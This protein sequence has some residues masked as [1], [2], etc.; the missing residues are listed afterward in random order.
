MGI[1]G[2]VLIDK[3]GAKRMLLLGSPILSAGLFAMAYYVTD[4]I[5][6]SIALIL[7]GIG[8]GFTFSAFQVLMLS[9]MPKD[10]EGSGVGILNTFKGIGGTIGP[11]A[12]SFFLGA[13]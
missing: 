4:S 9:F 1:M 3:F 6:L 2:G 5:T 11:L 12:G 8:M 10:E 13:A 7:I